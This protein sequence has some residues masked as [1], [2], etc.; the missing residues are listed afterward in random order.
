[1][2]FPDL[3]TYAPWLNMPPGKEHY[4]L[5]AYLSTLYN[6]AE[7]FDIGTHMGYS[8]LALSHNPNNVV[9]SFDIERHGALPTAPNIEYR[10][11][12]LLIPNTPWADR[13]LASPLIFFDIAPHIGNLEY[14][15]YVWL[16]DNH[17]QGIAVFDDIF[18]FKEMTDNFW[19]KVPAEHKLDLTRVGHWSG[20]GLVYFNP[21]KILSIT[22]V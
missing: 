12:N 1:M 21:S 19:D 11:E 4:K 7:I 13:L 22:E 20:T 3:P 15:F 17:Y 16:R 10:L 14:E 6:G 18:Y 9:L 5:L 2:Q 8:A